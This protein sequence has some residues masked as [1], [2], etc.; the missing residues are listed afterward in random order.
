[1]PSSCYTEN[2]AGQL[3]LPLTVFECNKSA[4]QDELFAVCD[5]NNADELFTTWARVHGKQYA[6]AVENATRRA[7]FESNARVVAAHNSRNKSFT[8]ELNQF[9]NLTWNAQ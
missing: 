9:A 2:E 6:S 5:A 3:Q 8:M 7:V 1:M 4:A